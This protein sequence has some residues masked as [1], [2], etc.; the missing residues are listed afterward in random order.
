[1]PDGT[2]PRGKLDSAWPRPWTTARDAWRADAT[3]EFIV[4][5]TGR[6]MEVKLNGVVVLDEPD[7]D[8][9]APEAGFAVFREP[10][11]F[12]AP[13]LLRLE[14]VSR[15]S[16]STRRRPLRPHPH[17]PCTEPEPIDPPGGIT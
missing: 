15:F 6:A 2:A 5:R 8:A 17:P 14:A 4:T 1:M 13:P 3:N 12:R 7:C 11:G 10:Y 16:G 9:P